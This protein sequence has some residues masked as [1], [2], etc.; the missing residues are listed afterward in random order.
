MENRDLFDRKVLELEENNGLAWERG[1]P[2]EGS[3]N[4]PRPPPNGPLLGGFTSAD[5]LE[6][7]PSMSSLPSHVQVFSHKRVV[8]I[9]RRLG[10]PCRRARG[11]RT[12]RGEG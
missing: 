3:R 12:C 6:W 9:P 11:L 1:Q 7:R 4:P 5:D 8:G 10:D 2:R